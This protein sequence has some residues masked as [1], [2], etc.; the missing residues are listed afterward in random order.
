ME[1]RRVEKPF[2]GF[3][4]YV[5][6]GASRADSFDVGYGV[7]DGLADA[8]IEC[9][10]FP[11]LGHMTRPDAESL[12]FFAWQLSPGYSDELRGQNTV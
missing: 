8:D 7:G 12:C 6:A 4:V 3:I 10:G 2:Q 9:E 5:R 11:A 1:N